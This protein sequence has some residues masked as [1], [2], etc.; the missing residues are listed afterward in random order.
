M[1]VRSNKTLTKEIDNAKKPMKNRRTPD[2]DRIVKE[3]LDDGRQGIEGEII[4]VPA[5]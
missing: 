3:M 4:K 2:E 1:V 5:A